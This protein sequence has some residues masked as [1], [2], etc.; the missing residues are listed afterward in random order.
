[1]VKQKAKKGSVVVK[2]LLAI[3][4]VVVFVA[5]YFGITMLNE[6]NST[7]PGTEETVTIEVAQ[8]ETTWDIAAKLKENGL[9]DYEVVFYL[10]ARETGVAGVLRYGTFTF[11]KDC[12]L[13]EILEVLTTGGAQKDS[14]M[15]TIPEGYTIEMIAKKLETE[16]ICTEAEFLDAVQQDY[17]Y[18]FL[19]NIPEDEAI[20][21]KLQGFLYPE[22]YAIT[23]EMTAEDIVKVMLNQFDKEFTEELRSQMEDQGKT[24]FEVVVIASMIERE[25]LIDSER[26]M[27]S[28]VIKN[29]MEIG[30]MLQID[31]TALY[32]LTEGLYDK[33]TVTYDDIAIDSPY[34]T[35]KYY[36][37]PIGPIANPSILSLEAALNPADHEFYYYHTDK[38]KN[39][40]SHIFTKT[41]EEHMNTQ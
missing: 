24:V 19:E 34:N 2:I 14:V 32:P 40:G 7:N 17:D 28:G 1:M 33:T 12:G 18:W 3:V 37:L 15:F 13:K 11:Q 30:M 21:Y 31:P 41:Y 36:G 10:K 35:Y 22:T 23:E 9:I 5:G 25:T 27:V 38:E 8:G 4:L 39:D 29:R 6:Y 26:V 20:R 16:G